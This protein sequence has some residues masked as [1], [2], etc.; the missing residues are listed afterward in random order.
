MTCQLKA[1]DQAFAAVGLL[2]VTIPAGPEVDVAQRATIRATALAV[3]G[4][5][6][7]CKPA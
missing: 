5:V 4:T 1:M 2:D 6:L 3:T 7:T